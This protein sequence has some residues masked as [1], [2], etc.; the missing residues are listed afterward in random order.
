[1]PT[2]FVGMS[3]RSS[4]YS[5]QLLFWLLLVSSFFI[6]RNSLM[7]YDS[8][9]D[10]KTDCRMDMLLTRYACYL[11][12]Q[13]GDSRKPEIAFAQNHFAVQTHRAEL[14]EQRLLDYERVK[15]RAKLAETEKVLLGVLYLLKS[16]IA[17]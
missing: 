13:N 15:A 16:D 10:G 7:I 5:P 2:P 1:M 9:L 3:R 8:L 17:R 14:V 4:E 6:I 12:A 11:V